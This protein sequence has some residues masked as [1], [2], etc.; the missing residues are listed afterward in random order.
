[1]CMCVC[2]HKAQMGMYTC[3]YTHVWIYCSNYMY[4]HIFPCTYSLPYQIRKVH[5]MM[6]WASGEKNNTHMY[7]Y[8]CTLYIQCNY[9]VTWHEYIHC[10]R[11][12]LYMQ[13]LGTK[14]HDRTYV[15]NFGHHPMPQIYTC[16]IFHKRLSANT[17]CTFFF[18]LVWNVATC[19]EPLLRLSFTYGSLEEHTEE[20][21]HGNVCTGWAW[22]THHWNTQVED[23]TRVH[24]NVHVHY[25]YL[26][27][28]YMK[29]HVHRALESIEKE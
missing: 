2:L 18:V 24:S 15:R 16:C 8:T 25:S 7:M 26:V 21:M 6:D 1:M 19:F 23:V 11:T 29:N 9:L 12:V 14:S 28:D 4:T 5:S 27:R 3:I 17:K 20:G 13:V 22:G 10:T